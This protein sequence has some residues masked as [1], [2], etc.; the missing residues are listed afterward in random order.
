MDS[1]AARDAS[2]GPAA[3]LP[4]GDAALAHTPYDNAALRDSFVSWHNNATLKPTPDDNTALR[5]GFLSWLSLQTLEAGVLLPVALIATPS[6]DA[7]SNGEKRLRPKQ[8]TQALRF[9]KKLVTEAFTNRPARKVA[10]VTKFCNNYRK[11]YAK[12]PSAAS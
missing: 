8:I 6:F 7:T 1:H 12:V 5:D 3:S 11:R 10:Q 2:L 4:H 9:R